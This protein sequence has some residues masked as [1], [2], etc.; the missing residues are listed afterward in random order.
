MAMLSFQRP[1]HQQGPVDSEMVAR[2]Q[3][4]HQGIIDHHRQELSRNFARQQ[5]VAIHHEA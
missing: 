4:L 2:E 3:T 5:P 1:S